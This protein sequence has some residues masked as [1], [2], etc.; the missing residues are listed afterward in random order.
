VELVSF[1]D[2]SDSETGRRRNLTGAE[3][4]IVGLLFDYEVGATA[5]SRSEK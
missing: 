2:L 1:F 5:L 3:V 4:E